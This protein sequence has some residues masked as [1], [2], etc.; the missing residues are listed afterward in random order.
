MWAVVQWETPVG[1]PR[2]RGKQQTHTQTQRNTEQSFPLF[3]FFSSKT[4]KTPGPGPDLA[5]KE[6]LSHILGRPEG[7]ERGARGLG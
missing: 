4:G 1:D 7:P 5:P 6:K 2:G 3:R